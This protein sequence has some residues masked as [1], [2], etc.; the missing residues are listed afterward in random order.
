[1]VW[2]ERGRGELL[3]GR[4]YWCSEGLSYTGKFMQDDGFWSAFDNESGISL[5]QLGLIVLASKRAEID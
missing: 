4:Q 2:M 1:M 3:V 5:L